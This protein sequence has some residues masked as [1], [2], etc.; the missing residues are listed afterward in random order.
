VEST[1]APVTATSLLNNSDARAGGAAIDE[2]AWLLV[3]LACVV[4]LIVGRRRKRARVT[5]LR[6]L[7]K[8]GKAPPAVLVPP[9]PVPPLIPGDSPK[10]TRARSPAPVLRQT[11]AGMPGSG[12][13]DYIAAFSD[14]GTAS[15]GARV[16]YL[17]ETGEATEASS[18]EE[19]R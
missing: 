9:G 10:A 18:G 4:G 19:G 15:E 12:G 16:D 6:L 3:A 5:L 14:P 17:L 11:P 8:P 13:I 7:N 2:R 1:A